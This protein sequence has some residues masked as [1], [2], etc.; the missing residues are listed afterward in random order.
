LIALLIAGIW[1]TLCGFWAQLYCFYRDGM[2]AKIVGPSAW[3]FGPEPF[4]EL[5]SWLVTPQPTD[6]RGLEAMA[7]GFLFTLA[8]NA[9]R[10]RMGWFPFHPVGYATSMS[11]SMNILWMPML[12][13]WLIKAAVIRYG[14]ARM[15]RRVL[16]LAIGLVLGEFVVGSFWTIYGALTGKQAYGFWV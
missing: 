14:G 1:G 11:W 4:N 15:S 8:L 7:F 5:R 10:I 2:S 9:L 16:P 12:I 13:A 6:A 3:A